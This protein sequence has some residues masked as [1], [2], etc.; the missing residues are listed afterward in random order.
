M[1]ESENRY[2]SLFEYNPSA[3][4]AMALDGRIESLNASLQHLTGYTRDTL[5]NSSYSELIDPEGWT[6]WLSVSH[7]L[8]AGRHSPLS[9]G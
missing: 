4:L 6:L 2:K 5:L 8:P 7:W 9:A 3:I 1:M